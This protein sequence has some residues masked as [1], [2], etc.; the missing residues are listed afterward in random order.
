MTPVFGRPTWQLGADRARPALSGFDASDQLPAPV[1]DVL[2]SALVS[3]VT[4]PAASA[5]EALAAVEAAWIEYEAS[6]GG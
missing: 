2:H 1:T 5:E 4:D 6:L 3:Y